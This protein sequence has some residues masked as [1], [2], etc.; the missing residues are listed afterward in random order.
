MTEHKFNKELEQFNKE[1]EQLDNE[2][3]RL[4]SVKEFCKKSGMPFTRDVEILLNQRIRNDLVTK[5]CKEHCKDNLI[6]N[7]KYFLPIKNY[8][9]DLLDWCID[10]GYEKSKLIMTKCKW[11]VSGNSKRCKSVLKD[12]YDYVGIYNKSDKTISDKRCLQINL[13]ALKNYCNSLFCKAKKSSVEYDNLKSI[14]ELI[15]GTIKK[16][17]HISKLTKIL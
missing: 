7:F 9:H 11:M 10:T 12:F 3:S 5:F 16:F 1:L 8:D 15:D 2:I 17:T 13:K 4:F 6:N 14:M